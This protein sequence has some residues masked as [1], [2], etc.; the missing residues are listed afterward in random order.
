MTGS[1]PPRLQA[2]VLTLR[3]RGRAVVDGVSLALPARGAVALVGP[4][5]AGK[6]TLLSLLA[7]L[8]APDAGRVLLDGADLAAMPVAQRARAMGYM[9]QHFAPH[10]DLRVDELVA[11]RLEGQQS[12]QDAGTVLAQAGLSAF[13]A[14]LWSTLSGGEQARAL[15]ATVLATDPPVLL[16]DE[17]GAALD[18]RHR[19][20][21]VEALAAR[22]RERLVVVAMHDLDLAFQHFGRVV[23]LDQGRVAL[24]GGAALLQSPSLDAV[25]GVRFERVAVPPH[26]L[27]RA[28]RL[29]EAPHA[30]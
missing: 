7:G 8:L 15:L 24:D 11:M 1:P 29:Q 5:G 2:Q 9:P 4:N 19:L 27:L 3:R 17:P 6:S 12:V 28:H 21:L 26:H 14:R 30:D 20:A 25:F 13:A 18:V 22:G 10:W 23:V 16:A